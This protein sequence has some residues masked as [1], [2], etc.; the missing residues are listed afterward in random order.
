MPTPTSDGD[1]T[2]TDVIIG[3]TTSA[4]TKKI[5]TMPIPASDGDSADTDV[6]IG[7]TASAVVV[8]AVV[9][10]VVYKK[11]KKPN[12]PIYSM[13]DVP[14]K[15]PQSKQQ[16]GLKGNAPPLKHKTIL[17]V[18]T[19][20]NPAHTRF[21][22]QLAMFLKVLFFI[23]DP[24]GQGRNR[25]TIHTNAKNAIGDA[26]ETIRTSLEDTEEIIL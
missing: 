19:E 18:S 24:S 4:D 23:R 6:I 8:V 25:P 9:L 15:D 10:L 16:I 1:S 21:V 5:T 17:I 7:V 11:Y 26:V 2:D 14:P 22:E 12:H 20:D 13:H 3:L